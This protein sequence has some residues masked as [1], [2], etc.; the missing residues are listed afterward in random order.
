MNNTMRGNINWPVVYGVA[1]NVKTGDIFRATFPESERGPEISLRATRLYTNTGQP[2]MLDIYETHLEMVKINPFSYTPSRGIELWLEQPDHVIL[3][4]SRESALYMR[5]L[6]MLLM[7]VQHL[8]TSPQVE[9][10]HVRNRSHR[11]ILD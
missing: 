2:E 9:P 10:P 3:K 6:T 5:L 1:C 11:A 8:S 4:V 7:D